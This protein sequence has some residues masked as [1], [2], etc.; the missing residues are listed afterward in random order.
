MGSLIDSPILSVDARDITPRGDIPR[1]FITLR[2]ALGGFKAEM[3]KKKNADDKVPPY[4]VKSA[5]VLMSKFRRA[6][7]RYDVLCYPVSV[8]SQLSPTGKGAFI[9]AV[10]TI[11]F[12]ALSDM[13][14]LDV[15]CNTLGADAQDKAAGKAFTYGWKYALIYSMLLPDADIKEVW[16]EIGEDDTDNDPEPTNEPGGITK[17]NLASYVDRACLAKSLEE[18]TGIITEMRSLFTAPEIKS[19]SA[20]LVDARQNLVNACVVSDNAAAVDGEK[21]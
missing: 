14:Y 17:P 13:S 7:D 19:V 5:K 4:A 12:V 3:V 18:F 16:D 1:L 10:Y 9:H 21:G 2:K 15:V 6:C 8:Q 11:R 20:E